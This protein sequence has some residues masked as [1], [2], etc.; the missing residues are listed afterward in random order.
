MKAAPLSKREEIGV[1]GLQPS[2]IPQ[3]NPMPLTLCHG[4][5]EEDAGAP[6]ESLH[7][8]NVDDDRAVPQVEVHVAADHGP[9]RVQMQPILSR[10]DVHTAKGSASY[11]FKAVAA[12]TSR[13]SG[14][15]WVKVFWS[16]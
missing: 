7:N 15:R 6:A 11:A 2:H 16:T 9:S 1:D 13:S 14:E 4:L 10:Q 5:I 12:T 3:G 8:S